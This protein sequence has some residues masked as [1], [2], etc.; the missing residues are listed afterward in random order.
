MAAFVYLRKKFQTLQ[1]KQIVKRK[2]KDNNVR[3]GT[4]MDISTTSGLGLRNDEED[5]ASDVSEDESDTR[6]V[7]KDMF[8][9][10]KALKEEAAPFYRR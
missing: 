1:V 5:S 7:D 3:K 10:A 4:A 2:K 8:A 6:S 9:F